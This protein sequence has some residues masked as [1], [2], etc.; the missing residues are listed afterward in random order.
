MT[1]T[2]QTATAPEER[3]AAQPFDDMAAHLL[4]VDDDR[5]IRSLLSRYLSEHGYRVTTAESAT[6]ARRRM[7]G[8]AFDLIVLD[9]MMPGESGLELAADIRRESDVAILMLTAKTEAEDRIEGLETGADDYL[10]K[11]FEPRE[12]LLRINN[13]LKRRALDDA[14]R[15]HV[16]FGPFVFHLGRGELKRQGEPVRLTERE[17]Q[18]LALFASRPQETIDRLELAASAD[19]SERAVDVQIN[20][21][22]R[23]IEID[24][25]N[26]R[27]L[28]TVRGIGYRLQID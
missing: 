21:L 28:Q 4:V 7:A 8:L 17:R 12:L 18:L 24:P 26:P 19:A 20:R 15:D 16:T 1:G 3:D 23:K 22:R 13:V 14:D 27:H 11:P 10:A 5:R 6:V 9:L 25:A 2:E